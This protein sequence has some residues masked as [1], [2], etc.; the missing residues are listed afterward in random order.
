MKR[1]YEIVGIFKACVACEDDLG[2][3]KMRTTV[4]VDVNDDDFIYM[5]SISLLFNCLL[6]SKCC[7]KC[8]GL[9]GAQ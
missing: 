6:I 7:K 8:Y 9:G 4:I 1:N 5:K 3:S 2:H